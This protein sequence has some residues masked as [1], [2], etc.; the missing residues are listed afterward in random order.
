MKENL[1]KPDFI[2]LG[3]AVSILVLGILI[4]SSASAFLAQSRYHDSY[5]LLKHQILLGVIP[6]LVLGFIMFH[7]PTE[8]I[9]KISPYLMF[10]A[11]IALSMVFI[12]GLGLQAGGAQRWIHFGS[13]TV[14][15]SE[16]LKLVSIIYLAGWLAAHLHPNVLATKR[17]KQR[18]IMKI[19]MNL[20]CR[21]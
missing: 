14:Q 15:P 17:K 10:L 8:F 3:A 16:I 6:G 7:L 21:F 18:R 20:Y 13:F 11:I 4:L 2:L 5:Y 1:A 19:K 9:R 12:P